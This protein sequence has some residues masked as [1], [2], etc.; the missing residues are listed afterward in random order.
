MAAEQQQSEILGD[1]IA[2]LKE[3]HCSGYN[4]TR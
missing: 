1:E 4:M 3:G 2:E